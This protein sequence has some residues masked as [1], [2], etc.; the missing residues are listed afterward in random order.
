VYA[1][2]GVDLDVRKGEF[3]AIVG[4]SGAGKT[5]LLN[6]MAGLDE[7]DYGIVLFKGKNLH[8]M[9]DEEKSRTRLIDMGFIFQSYALLPHYNTRENVSLPADLAGLSQ[10]LKTRIKELLEGVGISKQASQYPAQLSGGQM[11]RVA[12]A[13]ALTNRPEVLFADEPTGD[14]DSATGTQVMELIKK[15]HEETKTTI[16]VI[17]H[18][19]SVADYAERQIMLEDGIV[20]KRKLATREAFG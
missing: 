6:C 2:R 15:F 4:N 7:P 16:I 5:T 17:T 19:K 3:L 11:Q 14:L 1:L 12:I 8:S 13:R 18:E 10:T 20:S 9:K